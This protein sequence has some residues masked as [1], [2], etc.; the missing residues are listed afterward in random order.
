M[1]RPAP[2]LLASVLLA[3]SPARAAELA[4]NCYL[5]QSG[6]LGLGQFVRHIQ[7]DTEHG[8]VSVADGLRGG[9][10]RWLGN[11]RLIALDAGR[12]VFD[13][14]SPVSSGRTEIDRRNGAYVYRDGR[15]IIR[16]ACQPAEL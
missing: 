1:I 6:S 10:L 12:L 11:G 2:A 5:V 4:L 13:F 7:V 16:G 9:E 15:T 8:L 3:A 14:A